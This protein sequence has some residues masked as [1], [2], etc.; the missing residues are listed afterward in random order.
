MKYYA[1]QKSYAIQLMKKN[2]LATGKKIILKS[3][4]DQYT[5]KYFKV[6]KKIL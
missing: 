6:Y 4:P 2:P 1:K 3:N 5:K